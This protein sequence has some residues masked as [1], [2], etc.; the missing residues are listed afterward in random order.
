MI[1][2]GTVFPATDLQGKCDSLIFKSGP[3]PTS[4][5]NDH[6][7]DN[8]R[9]YNIVNFPLVLFINYVTLR[10]PYEIRYSSNAL[11]R[12]QNNLHDMR[13]GVYNPDNSEGANR[14]NVQNV[15]FYLHGQEASN[16]AWRSD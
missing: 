16:T 3:S 12:C 2:L 1:L 9:F 11:Q 13:G 8:I 6:I 15:P 5:V 10:P 14:G 7:E 4:S